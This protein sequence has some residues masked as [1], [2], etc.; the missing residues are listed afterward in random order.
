MKE[1]VSRCNKCGWWVDWTWLCRCKI[2]S[3]RKGLDSLLFREWYSKT[4]ITKNVFSIGNKKNYFFNSG[5]AECVTKLIE[6]CADINATDN[7]GST[8]YMI[9]KTH[10]KWQI[11]VQKPLN[12]FITHFFRSRQHSGTS[13][14]GKNKWNWN[15]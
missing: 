14:W 11:L 2:W 15:W 4:E 7:I 13:R 12:R 6:G 1:L 5:F 9:S 8:P 10:R 3:E